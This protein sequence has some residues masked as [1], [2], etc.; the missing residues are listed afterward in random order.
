MIVGTMKNLAKLPSDQRTIE[1]VESV[2]MNNPLLEPDGKK[3]ERSAK[4]LKS[5]VNF[6]KTD[7]RPDKSVV[8][9][10]TFP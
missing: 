10:V 7:G 1:N 3:T 9:E 6:F 4:L 8:E 5:G 2:M